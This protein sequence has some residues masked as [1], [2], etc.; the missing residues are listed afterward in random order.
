MFIQNKFGEVVN[1]D[2]IMAIKVYDDA[3]PFEIHTFTEKTETIFQF[4]SAE[5]VRAAVKKIRPKLMRQCLRWAECKNW[6]FRSDKILSI[7]EECCYN[8]T[9]S[10]IGKEF[11]VYTGA[12]N[13]EELLE[14]KNQIAKSL[15]ED[16]FNSGLVTFE[17]LD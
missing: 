9:V 10:M 8:L 6:W 14:Y 7:N 12:N 3:A 17:I 5:S 13:D 11:H 4:D 15:S 1:I 16:F 2:H